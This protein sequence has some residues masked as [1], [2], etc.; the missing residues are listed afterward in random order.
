M[1]V[2]YI[3]CMCIKQTW[4]QRTHLLTEVI[5][6]S[7]IHKILLSVF[8]FLTILYCSLKMRVCRY[9]CITSVKEK[10]ICITI[11]QKCIIR[12]MD[13]IKSAVY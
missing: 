7:R 9:V 1:R 13:L 11:S 8:F 2:I 6:E 3:L 5:F 4:A 10:L 12:K